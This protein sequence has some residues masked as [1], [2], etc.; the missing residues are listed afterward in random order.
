[1]GDVPLGEFLETIIVFL[2]GGQVLHRLQL[3]GDNRGGDFRLGLLRIEDSPYL[4]VSDDSSHHDHYDSNN[5]R[6]HLRLGAHASHRVPH[7]TLSGTPRHNLLFPSIFPM[8]A[9]SIRDTRSNPQPH[10]DIE[11]P[12][13]NKPSDFIDQESASSWN[14]IHPGS[15]SPRQAVL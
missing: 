7:R 10:I 15:R 4:A 8:P 9:Y 12:A 3:T 1:M 14:R 6:N 11:I 5:D 13:N 2:G